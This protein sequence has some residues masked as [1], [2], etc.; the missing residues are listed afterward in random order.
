MFEQR[1]T[2]ISWPF[3]TVLTAFA[4]WQRANIF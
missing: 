1:G 2:S 3:L 4:G